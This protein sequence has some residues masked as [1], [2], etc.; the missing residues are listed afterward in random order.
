MT[1]PYSV[2]NVSLN[3]LRRKLLQLHLGNSLVPFPQFPA[4]DPSLVRLLSRTVRVLELGLNEVQTYFP[5]R[6]R[7]AYFGFSRV[8]YLQIVKL[9]V[10]VFLVLVKI[11]LQGA[12]LFLCMKKILEKK[13]ND[14]FGS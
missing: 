5:H 9:L 6:C 1:I 2:A 3:S 4:Q 10:C 12:V 11:M 8:Y 7:R 13:K 14:K